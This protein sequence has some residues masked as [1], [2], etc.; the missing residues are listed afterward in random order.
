[1]IKSL[2]ILL[3]IFLLIPGLALAG[4]VWN[5]ETALKNIDN[6]PELKVLK[7]QLESADSQLKQAQALFLP[8][9]NGTVGYTRGESAVNNGTIQVDQPSATLTLTYNLSENSPAGTSL[10]AA[11]LNFYKAQNNYLS[12]LRNLKLKI[13]EQ[14]F[15]VLLAQKELELSERSLSLAEKQL[16]VAQDKFSKKAITES[17]LMDAQ[18]SLKGSQI[19]YE[20]AKNNARINLLTLFNTLGIP[21]R[22]ITLQ[23]DI[24]YNPVDN[25][26]LD[27][28]IKEAQEN[29]LDIKNARYDLEK[30]E[31]SYR[32]ATKSNLTF[33]LSGSYSVDGQSFKAGIDNQN[34]QINLS[35]SV[36]LNNTSTGS[37]PDWAV[38]L[39]ASL[40]IFE[41]G[42]KTET[43]KQASLALDQAKINLEN[44]ERSV[45]LNVKQ[46]YN[47][48]TQA[49]A[50]IENA[51]FNLNQKELLV[52]N[53]E[54]RYNLGLIIDLDLEAAKL[55]REQA[56]LERD[57]AIVNYNIALLQLNIILGKE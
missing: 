57:K 47:T 49:M 48:L 37:N 38:A 42:D 27:E 23:E 8:K 24:T 1:M 45:E 22:D 18:L 36:P 30:A 5:L 26:L 13:T 3:I 9:L 28:L 6:A 12:G 34:Y 15:N 16:S 11:R 14:F 32:D 33:G 17:N 7:A 44:T 35:Y 20:S 51:Q 53:A 50:Q 31:R 54:T 52:A 40:P 10:L 25:I 21:A 4:E 39:T 46:I 55:Q 41:G 2:R 56:S 19:S 29:N 43:V